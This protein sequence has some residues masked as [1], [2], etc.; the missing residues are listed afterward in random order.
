MNK[1]NDKC[2]IE[3]AAADLIAVTVLKD[4]YNY[5]KELLKDDNIN[6]D[7]RTYYLNLI[8]STQ[9]VLLHFGEEV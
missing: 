4:V 3:W 9:H 5:S 2:Y 6:E 8:V 1:T 7:I